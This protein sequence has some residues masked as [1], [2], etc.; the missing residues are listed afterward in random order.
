MVD[1]DVSSSRGIH[2]VSPKGGYAVYGGKPLGQSQ[3]YNKNSDMQESVGRPPVQK[4][5]SPAS[6]NDIYLG[7][8]LDVFG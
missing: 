6:N 5:A 1:G 3:E 4:N 2:G 8:N 7:N